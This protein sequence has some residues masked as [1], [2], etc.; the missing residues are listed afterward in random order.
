MATPE[1]KLGTDGLT[2]LQLRRHDCCLMGFLASL[3]AGKA[4]NA[5]SFVD[6]YRH[7][8]QEKK[9]KTPLLR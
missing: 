9:K 1:I 6:H 4:I 3:E 7:Q 2:R 8:K 5:F